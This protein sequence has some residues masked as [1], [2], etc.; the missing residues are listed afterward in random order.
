MSRPIPLRIGN[1][2]T[3]QLL[4]RRRCAWRPTAPTSSTS[5]ANP[6]GPAP[7][8]CPAE[9]ELARVLAGDSRPRRA[10]ARCRCRSTPTR[11]RRARGGR[12]RCGDRQRRQR[13][14]YDP[15]LA[16]VVAET[17]AALV[18]MHTRGRSKTHVHRGGL[19]RR[20][21]GCG[22]GTAESLEPRCGRRCAARA[23]DRRPR[24]RVCQTPGAQLWCAGAASG[25]AAALDRPVLVGPS[26][27]S[28]MREALADRP[29]PNGTGAPPP[30]SRPPS[31]AARTSSAC[32]RSPRWRRCA[33]GGRRSDAI[34]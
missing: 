29:P 12:R 13:P 9:E 19:R 26:R 22:R 30:P 5:A 20:C 24:D 25:L 1:G 21:R 8:R 17:G 7:S 2:S 14:A 3:R 6:R 28:F 27:K 10:G 15:A 32:T 23:H 34:G 31:S 33:G 16:D 18:L 11:P 4:S